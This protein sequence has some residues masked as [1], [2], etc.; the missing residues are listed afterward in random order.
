MKGEQNS[1][2]AVPPHGE[3]LEAGEELPP[4]QEPGWGQDLPHD[5]R[6]EGRGEARVHHWCPP[7]R[8]QHED[9]KPTQPPYDEWMRV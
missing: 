6:R 5:R 7:F 4:E 8:G 9:G 1:W 3:G 2:R